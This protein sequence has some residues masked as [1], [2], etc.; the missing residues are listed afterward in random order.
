LMNSLWALGLLTVDSNSLW[1]VC[2]SL[3][4]QGVTDEH[5]LEKE[6]ELWHQLLV[7]LLLWWVLSNTSCDYM[8]IKPYV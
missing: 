2:G 1:T 7:S 6:Y 4:D 3:R 5:M 8:L